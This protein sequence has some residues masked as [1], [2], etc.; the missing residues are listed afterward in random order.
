VAVV[1]SPVAVLVQ[2]APGGGAART[3]DLVVS[4]LTPDDDALWT[5]AVVPHLAG[6]GLLVATIDVPANATSSAQFTFHPV[7]QNFSTGGAIPGPVGPPGPKGDTGADGAQ[8]AQGATGPQGPAGATGP[9]GPT[10]PV[11]PATIDTWHDMRPL[12]NSFSH[13]GAGFLPAQ[14]RLGPDGMVDVAGWV[15]TPSGSGN[16]NNVTFGNIGAAARPPAGLTHGWLVTGI[17]D[18]AASPKVNVDPS[19]NLFLSF[20]PATLAQ[21]IFGIFGRFPSAAASTVNT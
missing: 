20:S 8:G 4:A 17:A 11:G 2:G 7:A 6:G 12:Q 10:G 14:Y 15:Q 19:G 16:R 9:Q 1:T 5:L 21:T 3:D 18:G 13:P